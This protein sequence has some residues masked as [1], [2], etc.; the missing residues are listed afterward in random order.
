MNTLKHEIAAFILAI[1]LTPFALLDIVILVLFLGKGYMYPLLV[2]FCLLYMVPALVIWFMLI[3]VSQGNQRPPFVRR[4][5]GAHVVFNILS[6][7]GIMIVAIIQW[8][9][10]GIYLCPLVVILPV[11]ATSVFFFRKTKNENSHS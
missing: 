9:N 8:E 5:W 4:T 3:L 6:L 7:L 11:L 10:S 2:L 1:L